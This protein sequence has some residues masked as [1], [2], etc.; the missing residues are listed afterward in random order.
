MS[1]YGSPRRPPPP[2]PRRS[3]PAETNA[4]DNNTSPRSAPPSKSDLVHPKLENVAKSVSVDDFKSI[5]E[6]FSSLF[7]IISFNYSLWR[8][9][10]CCML[11][12]ENEK[13]VDPTT[14][15]ENEN[16]NEDGEMAEL[17]INSLLEEEEE[18]KYNNQTSQSPRNLNVPPVTTP[19]KS[20]PH[21]QQ[22]LKNVDD[23][24]DDYKNKIFHRTF[25]QSEYAVKHVLKPVFNNVFMEKLAQE[26]ELTESM[27]EI[28]RLFCTLHFLQEEYNIFE[29]LSDYLYHQARCLAKAGHNI[30]GLVVKKDL[31]EEIKRT[32]TMYPSN[33]S[34]R[35][36]AIMHTSHIQFLF[37]KFMQH[38]NRANVSC[39]LFKLTVQVHIYMYMHMCMCI[40]YILYSFCVRGHIDKYQ[41][42]N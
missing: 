22:S 21:Q 19:K 30:T 7:R 40:L 3:P 33:H 35:K 39:C 18:K 5:A 20:S 25:E 41:T 14:T 42:S 13:K 24:D 6:V 12:I 11:V 16:K 34:K 15:E 10:Q 36:D 26:V 23:D 28:R 38:G 4:G 2:P 27:H 31:E 37:R 32:P 1:D 29:T 17:N 9:R 8:M